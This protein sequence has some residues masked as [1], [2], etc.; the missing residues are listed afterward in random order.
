MAG[1][2]TPSLLIDEST[3]LD[4]GSFGGSL[5]LEQQLRIDHVLLTHAHIDHTKDLAL[6]A[7]LVIGHRSRP[8]KVH[9]SAGAMKVLRGDFFNNRLWPDFFSLPS[10]DAPVLQEALITPRKDFR[11]GRMRV[12]PIPVNHPVETVGFLIRGPTGSFVY[13]GDTGPTEA[14][15]KSAGKLR[16]LKLVF[17]ECKFPNDLQIVADAAGHLTPRTLA[18]EIAQLDNARIPF[19]VYHVKPDW[20]ARVVEQIEALADERIH[21]LQVGDRFQV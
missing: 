5:D 15:W 11:I 14:L 17:V 16:K 19:Y 13:S 3:L 2:N 20:Y 1:F 6:F 10:P 4:A 12:S 21:I 8:V 18:G 7:D 9:A